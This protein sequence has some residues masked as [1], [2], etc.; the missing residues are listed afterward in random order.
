MTDA[1]SGVDTVLLE[2]TREGVRI[3][4]LN[5]PERK[6]ALS[7]D[8]VEL[9]GRHGGAAR[10]LDLGLVGSPDA[11]LEVRGGELE[12]AG[13]L[14]LPLPRLE[15]NVGEDGHGVALLHDR[16][17]ARQ[18]LLELALRYRDLHVLPLYDFNQS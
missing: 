17:D 3:L 2:E 6:N 12:P 8:L 15:E 11:D 4:R 9:A 5:R 10:R 7:D 13:L 1:G 18:A 14:A 16:L